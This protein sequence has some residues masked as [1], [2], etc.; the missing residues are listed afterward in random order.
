MTFEELI[1]SLESWTEENELSLKDLANGL[2]NAYTD[3]E[4]ERDS[5]KDDLSKEERSS[6]ELEKKY[7]EVQK[8]NFSLARK[9]D[10]STDPETVIHNMFNG[11]M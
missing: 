1:G 7:R 2:R 8:T 11:G 5:L 9:F 10:I 6:K 3:L 4:M